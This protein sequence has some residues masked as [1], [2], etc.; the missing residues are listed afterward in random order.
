VLANV[1][2]P[3]FNQFT[4]KHLS[5]GF[6]SDSRVW[7]LVIVSA[8]VIGFLSGSYP[9]MFLSGFKPTA[10][11]K[12]MKTNNS[13]SMSLRKGLIVFQFTISTVMIFATIILFLQVRYLNTTNLG[14]NKE[15]LVVIDVNTNK[16]RSNYESIKHEISKIPSVK[17]VSATSRVPGEWKSFRM[18]KVRNAGNVED[19]KVAYLFGADKDFTKTFQVDLLK[20]RNFNNAQDSNSIIINETAAH[21]LN[22]REPSDQLVEIPAVSRGGA[23]TPFSPL[24]I[25]FKPRIIGIVKDFHFQSLRDKIEPLILAY[26]QN[27]IH[28]IDYYTARIEASD[29]PATLEKLKAVMVNNDKDDPFEYHFLNEQLALFYIEDYRRQTLL[30]WIAISTI[31]IA[32]LGLFGLAT[33]T[34][35]QRI[36]EIG[37]RKVLGATVFNLTTLQSKD[38]LK[39]VF[40]AILIAFP[41]A[42][43]GANRWLQEYA[44]HIDIEWWMFAFGSMMAVTIALLTVCYQAVKAALMNPVKALRT[45]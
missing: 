4:N 5:L 10:L 33:Y 8:I 16:A 43:W 37:V 11:I 28:V 45:E 26:D 18:V 22:I 25:P 35:E 15:L 12:G 44:Y 13:G 9:A 39:L 41:V 30:I 42:W 14:F 6:S 38:F 20:G 24:N 29:I 36:K 7:L 19:P 31:F 27:P 34:A 40:I 32:C 1:I 21:L 17:S 3:A 2:L 23:S